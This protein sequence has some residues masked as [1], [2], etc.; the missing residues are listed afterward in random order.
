[1]AGITNPV[2]V[3]Q[4]ATTNDADTISVAGAFGEPVSTLAFDVTAGDTT[5]T[6]ALGTDTEFDT[7]T[8]KLIFVGRREL[9]RIVSQSGH[10]LTIS[11]D[12]VTNGVGFLN[13]FA[14]DEPVELVQVVTYS[15]A[16]DPGSFPHVPHVKRDD[17]TG[18]LTLDV[19][20]IVA[21]NIENFQVEPS[22]NLFALA[23]TARTADPDGKYT[24]PTEGDHYRRMG[25]A[26]AARPRN[27]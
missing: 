3:V 7:T 24:H 4:G 14:A 9:A 27:R 6:V 20:K 21:V 22:T 1:V 13:N 15:W 19:Q 10:M 26:S 23:L 16:P 17:N 8:R 11:T 12:P 2:T 18:A 25:F 5:L